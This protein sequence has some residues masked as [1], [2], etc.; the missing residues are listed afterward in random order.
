VDV[1]T[2]IT[3][4]K[5]GD[6]DTRKMIREIQKKVFGIGFPG[7]YPPMI[8]AQAIATAGENHLSSFPPLY[9]YNYE[10]ASDL[11]L[12]TPNMGLTIRTLSDLFPEPSPKP[13]SLLH[14]KIR[15]YF[16]SDEVESAQNPRFPHQ[17]RVNK[18][19][20]SQFAGWWVRKEKGSDSKA[21]E[22]MGSVAG[23]GLLQKVIQEFKGLFSHVLL[24]VVD[25][26][27]P[28]CHSFTMVGT[29]KSRIGNIDHQFY[30]F[31]ECRIDEDGLAAWDLVGHPI[32]TRL[33][34]VDPKAF[35]I[36]K[37]LLN[38]L[39][40]LPELDSTLKNSELLDGF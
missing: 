15:Y 27:D 31:G 19:S 3:A 12:L 38:R 8:E 16:S 40:G 4:I 32:E 1:A 26:D 18:S 14:N 23:N 29:M 34:K 30:Q 7:L 13:Y 2:V 37:D 28:P 21:S 20:P 33:S 10:T 24:D 35:P 22:F 36:L 5:T 39:N 11:K 17:M 25:I 6:P 9:A